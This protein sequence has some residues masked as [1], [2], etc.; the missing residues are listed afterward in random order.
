M[1]VLSHQ[2]WG[3]FVMKKQM[4]D[5]GVMGLPVVMMVMKMAVMAV[6]GDGSGEVMVEVMGTMMMTLDLLHHPR[7]IFVQYASCIFCCVP[8]L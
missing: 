8:V 7:L 2:V 6:V 4:T 1:V 5:S 3:W